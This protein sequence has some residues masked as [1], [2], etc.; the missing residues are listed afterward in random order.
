METRQTSS[1][2]VP[3]GAGSLCAKVSL[4]ANSLHLLSGS[5]FLWIPT[6]SVIGITR[7]YALSSII[8]LQK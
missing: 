1:T 8:T 3:S 6:Q 4:L 5:R 7:S 2:Q